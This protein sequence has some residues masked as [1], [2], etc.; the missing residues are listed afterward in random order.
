MRYSQK[1]EWISFVFCC[2]QNPSSARNLETTGLMQV[3]F[4]VKC[5]SP[6]EHFNQI[7]L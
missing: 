6:N 3:G 5:S 4:S 7:E 1:K 2:F